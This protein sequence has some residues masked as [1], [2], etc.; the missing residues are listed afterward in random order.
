MSPRDDVD[1]Q[2][3]GPHAHRDGGH[4][5]KMSYISKVNKLYYDS[6]GVPE[7]YAR[8]RFLFAPEKAIVD[9]LSGVLGGGAILDIGIGPGRTVPY[10]SA[11][12]AK[13]V[14][15][16]YSPNM[17]A[18]A[19]REFPHLCL[20]HADARRLSF[21][22]GSFDAVFFC[23]NAI[24]DVGHGERL[25]I[26]AEVR[27]VLVAGGYFAF[28]AH[29]LAAPRRSAFAFR[30]L[31]PSPDP[32]AAI[33]ENAARIGRHVR[34]V[35]NHLCNRPREVHA[36]RYSIINDQAHGYRLLTYY[37]ARGSQVRQL[38]EA[39]FDRV[40]IMDQ[41]GTYITADDPCDDGWVYYLARK[42]GGAT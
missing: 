1:G 12:T 5:M 22:D 15:I 30:G 11:L 32:V 18:P 42:P 38:E 40:E 26:L 9:R 39:G 27:R 25:A 3:G 4:V 16:D 14:G 37:I 41:Q 29:N 13:Y 10:L 34:N 19:R 8:R 35:I 6:P 20:V 7:S 17:L 2:V 33:R 21:A 31:A 28:S 23:W 36:E 24:D